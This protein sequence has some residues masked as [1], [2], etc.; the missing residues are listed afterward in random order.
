MVFLL[1][2]SGFKVFENYKPG[3]GIW[4]EFFAVIVIKFI[5]KG[6]ECQR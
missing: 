5:L 2:Q 1:Y 4:Q 3:T 6:R